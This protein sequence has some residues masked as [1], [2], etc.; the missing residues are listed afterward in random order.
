VGP[1]DGVKIL[2]I[3]SVGPG[4]FA[5]ML[6][7][8]LGADV[9]RIVRPSQSDLLDAGNA[10]VVNRGRV[11]LAVNLK[12]ETGRRPVLELADRADAMIE[13]FRPGVM[14]RLGLGPEIAL[15]R[16]PRL[17]YGRITGFGQDGPSACAAGHDINYLALSGALGAIAREGDRP[18]PPINL[19]ADYA[20]GGLLAAFGV[21]CALLEARRSGRGQLSMPPWW[22][23]SLS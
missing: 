9:L 15:A 8:D 17:V 16:N 19:L 10:D 11:E 5:G 12:D 14:E 18:L 21:V 1:L 6:F 23:A 7:A 3:A 20:G 22:T 13:G 2:E 4:P